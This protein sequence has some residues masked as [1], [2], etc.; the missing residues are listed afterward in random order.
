MTGTPVNNLFSS[1]TN[2]I[3]TIAVLLFACL[4]TPN[5]IAKNL[6]KSVNANGKITYS[7]HPP[8]NSQTTR[9]ISLL[10]NSPKFSVSAN[11]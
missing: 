1:K 3:A 4:A 5:A 6:Y 2:L 9:N 11:R 8:A 7:N 10:K